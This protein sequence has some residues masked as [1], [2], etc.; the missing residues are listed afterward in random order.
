MTSGSLVMPL[1][2]FAAWEGVEV[3]SA[4]LTRSLS[5]SCPNIGPDFVISLSNVQNFSFDRPMLFSFLPHWRLLEMGVSGYL[6]FK[7]ANVISSATAWGR[8]FSLRIGIC[9]SFPSALVGSNGVDS[10]FGVSDI[11]PAI[12]PLEYSVPSIRTLV[13]FSLEL[14]QSSSASLERSLRPMNSSNAIST[15]GM[16]RLQASI[17]ATATS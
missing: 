9:R 6:Q 1:A 14:L 16:E 5:L 3:S 4:I 17:K 2:S 8:P 12:A 11:L 10:R 15:S 7:I 13:A